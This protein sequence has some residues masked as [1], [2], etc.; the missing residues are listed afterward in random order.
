MS[1]FVPNKTLI[2]KPNVPKWISRD[3]T[4]M[5]RRQNK[6]YKKYKKNGF[7]TND[8]ERVDKFREECLLAINTSKQNYLND[9]GTKL[10][11]K[12]LGKKS[13]WKIIN[14]LMNK[15]KTPRIPPLLVGDKFI[16]SC[17]EKASLF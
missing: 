5:M 16:S 11:D 7:N 4:N 6:L 13:Y 15:C 3:I 2:S 12:N 10:T 9:L 1:N 14:N 8:K 17:K